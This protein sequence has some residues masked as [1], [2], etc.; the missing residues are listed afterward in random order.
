MQHT[1]RIETEYN[2]D[3]ASYL[4]CF[5]GTNLRRTEITCMV[6]LTQ[7]LCGATLIGYAP[8]FYEQAGFN[9]GESFKLATGVF[10]LAILG[11]MISWPLLPRIGRRQ[12]YIWGLLV[13]FAVQL[14]AA[15]VSVTVSEHDSLNW[16]IGSLVMGL[17]FA[18]N[19]TIGP[20][21]YTLVAEIP[22]T[23]LRLR[24][25]VL[26]R[27]AY[28]CATIG[29]NILTPLMLNPTAWNWRGKS[30]FWFTA[31]TLLCL[32]WCFYRLPESKG[33][34]YLELDILFAKNAPA[35]KFRQFQI[36]LES[37]GYLGLNQVESSPGI[38]HGWRGY[39]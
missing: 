4:D 25:V 28:N 33:L 37:S 18:Y 23:Q 35:H 22:S 10:G 15:L 19:I 3:G 11:N 2:Q 12:L 24:T 34:S 1:K 8:Y 31:T 39:S 21:C 20:V 30:C 38:W 14:S 26:A 16:I 17:I 13:L 7:A 6:W 9:Q 36:N 32:A 27:V 29:N 5:R